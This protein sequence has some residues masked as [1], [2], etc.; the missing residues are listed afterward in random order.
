[1]R[2]HASS[3]SVRPTKEKNMT[4]RL[5]RRAFVSSSNS[6]REP[7]SPSAQNTVSIAHSLVYY[8]NVR[9]QIYSWNMNK[10]RFKMKRRVEHTGDNGGIAQGFAENRHR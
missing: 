6:V 4:R 3:S 9:A 8:F 2:K 1:M 5:A 10:G 7:L